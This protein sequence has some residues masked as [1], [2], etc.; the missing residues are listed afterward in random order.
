M[1]LL[2]GYNFVR[3]RALNE[4]LQSFNLRFPGSAPHVISAVGLL[5]CLERREELPGACLQVEGFEQLWHVVEDADAL[6][7]R[8]KK[9]LSRRANWL[10]GQPEGP[11]IYFRL[12]DEV[13]FSI[14]QHVNLRLPN[15]QLVDLD[16]VFGHPSQVSPDHYHRPL[17]VDS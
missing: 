9:L 12:P 16:L 5:R 1:A 14:D 4:F 8:I 7:A 17:A 6:A 10:A 11:F 13:E 3:G 15:G 2:V